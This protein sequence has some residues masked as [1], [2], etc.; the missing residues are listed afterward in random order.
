MFDF[1]AHFCHSA[2]MER[3]LPASNSG[4]NAPEG[5]KRFPISFI[6]VNLN[7]ATKEELLLIPGMGD[8]MVR[9]F[10]EYRPYK[11]VAQFP[12]EIGKYVNAREVARLERYVALQ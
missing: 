7:T 8:R 3:T 11:D 5:Q 6:H 10:K 12:R 4:P 1:R 2:L 9:E